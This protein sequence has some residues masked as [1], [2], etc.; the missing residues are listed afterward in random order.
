LRALEF[1]MSG[2][3]GAGSYRVL[4][5]DQIA[6]RAFVVAA[7]GRFGYAL[8][9]LC[10]LFT[11]VQATGSFAV[12]ATASALFGISGLVMPAQSRLVDRRGQSC[13]LPVVGAGFVAGLIAMALLGLSDVSAAWVWYGTALLAGVTAPA[14]G[15][16]MRAQW[17]ELTTP[18]QRPTAYS[19][20]AVTE[21]IVFLLGPIAAA[22]VLATGP[23]WRGVLVVAA[24]IP[25]GVI[26]LARSPAAP[27]P[28]P[29]TEP[30][31]GRADWLGP[32]RRGPF[33]RLLTVMALAGVSMSAA[34]T[35]VAAL[36]D[37]HHQ[38]SATGLVEAGGGVM[39]I[40]GGLY[41]GRRQ[42]RGQWQRELAGLLLLRAPFM[43]A[44]V[45][46]PHL[47]SVG[48]LVALASVAV[49]PLYV[50]AFTTSDQLAPTAQHTEASTWVTALTNTGTSLGTALAGWTFS[51]GGTAPVFAAITALL[52]MAALCALTPTSRPRT[53]P[54]VD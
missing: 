31:A 5:A 26:G 39:A 51:H 23:A 32:L 46:L 52:A 42:A 7:V 50:V 15:P 9:P 1:L 11:I 19:L 54:A 20:D 24:L 16:S 14:L 6:R 27:P 4:L 53:G 28:R 34:L 30:A 13:V 18:A 48:T 2:T 47:W 43:G 38:P 8:L 29:V 44:C 22:G 35:G 3:T 10:L 36:A 41:W 37:A 49:S 12:A 17:R 25:V 40:L 33:R 21:E 45:L